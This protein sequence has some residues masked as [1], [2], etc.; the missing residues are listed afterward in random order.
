MVNKQVGLRYIVFR[1]VVYVM[2]CHADVL[3]SIPNKCVFIL[4]Q[5]L[6]QVSFLD[7]HD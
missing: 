1:S 6:R 4:N 2:R 7:F 5:F 3:G